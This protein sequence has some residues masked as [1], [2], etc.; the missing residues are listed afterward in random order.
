MVKNGFRV[1]LAAAMLLAGCK[2]ESAPLP[3]PPRATDP[4]PVPTGSSFVA[5]PVEADAAILRRVVEREVPQT[6][7]SI[8][9]RFERCV[10]PQRVK[11]L[12]QRIKLAPKI[13]CRVVGKVTRSA[14]RLHGEGSEIVADVPLRAI[15]QARDVG[16]IIKHETAT[17]SAM[18][19]ARIRLD[20]ASDWSPRA[21]VKLRY[22]WTR[23]PG[24]DF[25][26]QRIE[27]TK[28]AD[29]A[30][31]PIVRR[32]ERELPRELQNLRLR[33][34]V[35]DLWQSGFTVL[36]LNEK[37]PPVWMRLTPLKVHYGGY[38]FRG[39]RITLNLGLEAKTETFVG[40]KPEPPKV[41]ALPAPGKGLK[42][43][44]LEFFL[45]VIANYDQ[46][47]PV[48][49]RALQKRQERPFTLPALGE[50]KAEFSGVEVYATEGGRIA[51]GIDIAAHQVEAP[52]KKTKGK[53]WLTATPVTEAGSAQVKF[54]N[55]EVKGKT[56]T[57]GG[58][59]LVKVAEQFSFSE[60]IA[61]AL[62][63]NF[64]VDLE[65]LQGKIRRA[66][67]EKRQGSLLIR[68]RIDRF[69]TGEITA[70]G[71]GLYMPVRAFGTADIRYSPRR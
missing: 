13:G 9:Q 10:P 42:G 48:I 67:A 5:V 33:P 29:K 23:E 58:N 36:S 1:L 24:I 50:V 62:A 37:D 14:I 53:V 16:G 49:L 34:Q 18:A 65:D 71:Q 70:Y 17:G 20:L 40:E 12:G 45:P 28:Q 46:L 64:T 55:V 69:E 32:L 43:R 3:A 38:S 27:F 22:N 52:D 39:D 2:Q 11:V 25:L 66:L 6:L 47:Q 56:D 60:T 19:Q 41:V 35:A 59:L 26:G 4:V 8:D 44:G 21:T 61:D 31:Q 30:L 54:T 51:V 68:T 63:Q 15:V 57:F 7:W